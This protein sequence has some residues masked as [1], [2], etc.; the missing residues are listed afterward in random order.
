MARQKTHIP[1]RIYLNG[2]L[3]GHLRKSS[4]GAIDFEYDESWLAWEHAMPISLSL[5]LREDRYIGRPVNAVF[6]NLLPDN[7][8]IRRKLA[9]RVKAEGDDAYSLLTAVGRL[10]MQEHRGRPDHAERMVGLLID[11]LRYRAGQAGDPPSC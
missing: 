8:T 7:D 1:L 4:A 9:E 2:R 5:P 10:S 11:G 3:V 6:D